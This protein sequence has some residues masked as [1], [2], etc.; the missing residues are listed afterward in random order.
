MKPDAKYLFERTM[1]KGR[2]FIMREHTGVTI[3]DFPAIYFSQ[4]E[5]HSGNG[6]K[7]IIIEEPKNSYKHKFIHTLL[8]G[9]NMSIDINY[10]PAFPYFCYGDFRE[11]A[12]LVQFRDTMRGPTTF[13]KAWLNIWFFKDKEQ[14]SE[15][16]YHQWL[17][18]ELILEDEIN[19]YLYKRS[20]CKRV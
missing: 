7:Y 10:L 18:G 14:M 6:L 4:D 16:L 20:Y 15:M 2:R 9:D 8:L 19:K 12:L 5:Q 3:P 17:S 1:P 13:E 11:D